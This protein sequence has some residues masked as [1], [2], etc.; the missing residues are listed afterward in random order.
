MIPNAEKVI[1]S[2]KII[3][4]RLE[5]YLNDIEDNLESLKMAIEEIEDE[6]RRK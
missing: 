4:K 3:A 2:M 1:Q 6:I 5:M